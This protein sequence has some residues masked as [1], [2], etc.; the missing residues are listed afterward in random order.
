[1]KEK[2]DFTPEAPAAKNEIHQFAVPPEEGAVWLVEH[3]FLV[4]LRDGP[5]EGVPVGTHIRL[6]SQLGIQAFLS[7]KVRPVMMPTL[8]KVLRHIRTVKNGLWVDAEPG[9]LI[10]ITEPAETLKLWREGYIT[11]EKEVAKNES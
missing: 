4:P 6:D 3:A 2:K 1:M 10:K 9:D 11:P 5:P 7:G 8:F